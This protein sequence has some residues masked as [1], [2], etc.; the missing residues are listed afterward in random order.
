[1]FPIE[2]GTSDHAFGHAAGAIAAVDAEVGVLASEAI[3]V[4]R[5]LPIDAAGNR[6]GI[7]VDEQLGGV[8][9]QAARRFPGA[10]DAIAV[11]LPRLQSRNV[12]M[13]DESGLFAQ[14]DA[15][16]LA[17]SAAVVETHFDLGRVFRI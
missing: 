17:T 3:R 1:M 13:P 15:A 16:S 8:E 11:E 7:R 2:V 5:L 14:P 4:D 6:L 9:A 10:M 12:S